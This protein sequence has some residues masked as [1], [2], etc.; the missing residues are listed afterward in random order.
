MHFSLTDSVYHILLFSFLAALGSEALKRFAGGKARILFLALASAL[1][2]LLIDPRFFLLLLGET[3]A[4]FLLGLKVRG[5]DG[6]EKPS[7]ASLTAGIVLVLLVLFGFKYLGLLQMVLPFRF[8]ANLMPLGISYYSFRLISYLADV[9]TGKTGPEE[10]WVS[11]FV[12]TAFFPQILSGPIVRAPGMLERL[13]EIRMSKEREPFR[14][15]QWSAGISLILSGLFKKLVIADRIGSYVDTIFWD[16]HLYPG[17]AL[18]MAAF[19]YSVQ[20][21]CD[22][23]GYSEIAAGVTNLLGFEC[24]ANFIR[25]YLSWDMH[26]FWRRW[27]IS[28]SQWLRDYVYIPLGGSRR[29]EKRRIFNVLVLFTAC[30]L[31]HGSGIKYLVWGL[32][33]GIWNVIPKFRK[34]ENLLLRTGQSVL[35]TCI[36]MFGWILFRAETFEKVYRYILRMF[37]DFSLSVASIQ[38][39]VLPFTGDNTCVAHFLTAI[40]MILLLLFWEIREEQGHVPNP[41][42]RNFICLV[43]VLFFGVTGSGSFLYA[44]Y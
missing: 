42:V 2:Y 14:E 20:L 23:A 30:G 21:Y 11:F 27:H 9:Y 26:E 37:T 38:A 32:Y 44:N 40:A 16:Y 3:Y 29:G 17:L 41:Y 34:Q 22:F 24:P 8:S 25:A 6:K 13:R 4:V 10:E 43:L 35:T 18:W 19:F 7:A 39:S 28:L 1:F 33:H 5:K 12:Y 36:A 15:A 31:W